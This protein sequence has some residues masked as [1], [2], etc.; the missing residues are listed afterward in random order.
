M[1]GIYNRIVPNMGLIPIF[2]FFFHGLTLAFLSSVRVLFSWRQGGSLQ[3]IL[4]FHFKKYFDNASL[5]GHYR[6][7]ERS[8]CCGRG[9]RADILEG[10]HNNNASSSYHIY[11]QM[12]PKVLTTWQGTIFIIIQ[13]A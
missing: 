3:L 8:V 12:S 9:H 1:V 2:R 7:F 10:I 11:H 13:Q 6:T 4:F 5:E